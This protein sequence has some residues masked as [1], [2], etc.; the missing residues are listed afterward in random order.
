MTD[1]F[2]PAWSPQEMLQKGVFGGNYFTNA[3][4][5][6]LEGLSDDVLA[7]VDDNKLE[8]PNWD[9]NYFRVKAGK[10]YEFWTNRGW[11]FPEDPIGWFHWY[12]RYD[13]GR[14]HSRDEHQIQRWTNYVRWYTHEKNNI[15]LGRPSPVIRQGLLQWAWAIPGL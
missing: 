9:H 4:S 15:K 3:T 1:K 11:I 8:D 14:R 13:A 6:D 5:D 12:C 7:C 10:D 2:K